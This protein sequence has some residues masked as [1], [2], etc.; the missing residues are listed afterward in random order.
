M[1]IIELITKK[2]LNVFEQTH[3]AH[4]SIALC[5]DAKTLVTASEDSTIA[6]WTMSIQDDSVDLKL[7]TNLFGHR[8]AISILAVSRA[9]GSLLSGSEDGHAILWDLNSLEVIREI[10][11]GQRVE[12]SAKM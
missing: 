11:L 9:F 4:V 8:K 3:T 10:S 2:L 1:R 5:A 12:V 6:V 7:K